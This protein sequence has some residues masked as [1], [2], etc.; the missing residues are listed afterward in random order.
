[1][2]TAEPKRAPDGKKVK[3]V[4]GQQ[5]QQADTSSKYRRPVHRANY[6]V[7]QGNNIKRVPSKK[8]IPS[9]ASLGRSKSRKSSDND[10]HNKSG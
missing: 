8:K 3:T 2:Y 5:K 10:N 4:S 9:K 6:P 7:S 1:M